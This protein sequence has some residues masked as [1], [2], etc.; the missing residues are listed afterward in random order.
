MVGDC[1]SLTAD[2]AVFRLHRKG[3]KVTF[4][5]DAAG[6]V[7]I[8]GGDV[9]IWVKDLDKGSVVMHEITHAAASVMQCCGIP[10][11]ADTEEVLCYL[12]GYLKIHLMD[13]IYTKR[14]RL[15][16]PKEI[17]NEPSN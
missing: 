2:A 5:S 10:L 6:C 4:T 13:K 3:V 11:N 7:C 15:A 8:A 17:A 14:E 16:I 12:V 9:F 1:D